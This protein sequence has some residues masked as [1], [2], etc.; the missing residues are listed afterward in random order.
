MADYL[1][2]YNKKSETYF[3]DDF[4]LFLYILGASPIGMIAGLFSGRLAVQAANF[5]KEAA[6]AGKVAS[7]GSL[8]VVVRS[9][10]EGILKS[11]D[12]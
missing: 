1:E 9:I 7:P 4:L 2:A 10:G 3:Y 5:F 6:K 12:K 8:N 11:S